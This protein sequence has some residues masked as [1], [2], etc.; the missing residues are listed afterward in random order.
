MVIEKGFDIGCHSVLI[1]VLKK[2]GFGQNFINWIE[3]LLK[4]QNSFLFILSLKL[5]FLLIK[6]NSKIPGTGIFDN[7]YLYSAYADETENSIELVVKTFKIS[8]SFLV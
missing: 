4:D 5:L 7:C 1:L 8:L 3:T 2:I 6:K